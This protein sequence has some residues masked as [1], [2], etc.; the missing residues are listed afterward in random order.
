M[1]IYRYMEDSHTLILSGSSKTQKRFFLLFFFLVY[2]Y[3]ILEKAEL[4][5]NDKKQINALCSEGGRD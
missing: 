3:A 1:K 2:F 4:I 5:C